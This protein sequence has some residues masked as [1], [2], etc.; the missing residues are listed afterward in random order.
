MTD[1]IVVG[2]GPNGLAGAVALAQEGLSV[3]VLEADATIGGGTRS[4]E[5]TVPG[6]LHDHC[7]AVHPMAV[8]SPF[9]TSLGLQRHGLRW[10]WPEVDLAHPL[11][12]G[13]GAALYRS[14][15]RTAA[16]L[17]RDGATW[18]RLFAPLVADFD[19]LAADLMGPVLRMP[20]HPLRLAR[21]GVRAAVP[22]APLA[23][24]WHTPAA[25]AL[26]AGVAAHA[27][28]PLHE[29]GSAAIG[30]MLIAAG[31][32]HGWPVARGGSRAITDAL[33][34]RLFELGGTI[35]TGTPVRSL[36]SLP[37]APIVLLDVAP[38]AAARI[39]GD[40]LPARIARAYRRWRHG[41]AVFKLDLAVDGG[42]PWRL[43]AA[44]RAGTVHAVGALAEIA[45]AERAV[46][47]G[48]LPQRPYVLVAQQYLA[49]PTRSRGNLHPVYAYAHVPRGYD[50]D[51]ADQ[52]L[53]QIERFAPG[54]RDRIVAR[55]VRSPAD[56]AAT[57]PSYVDGDILT[58]A[59]TP[60]Q[61]VSRPRWSP[62]PYATGI[63]G[64]YLCSAATP[65]GAGIHGMCGYHAAHSA[66][67]HLRLN[68][69]ART[70]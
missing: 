9:L 2:S 37:P 14:I 13:R 31:H 46:A 58:G 24:L 45:R 12:G 68:N 3:T 15:E 44:R 20:R 57:N 38:A 65:P 52:I 19:T 62:D 30:T 41:P 16:T 25:R 61:L 56:F 23:R 35:E 48:R 8:A 21:F 34:R 29:P 70:T 26:F 69:P 60:R 11:D 42:I 28:R 66:L 47:A 17:G 54:L 40:R 5:L 39:C 32:R 22:A 27:M 1:A 64:V 6:L 10:A 53:D 7:S 63:P 50:G 51:A 33:A 43:D 18:R 4:G 59:N 36:A 55:S 67:R 49:D